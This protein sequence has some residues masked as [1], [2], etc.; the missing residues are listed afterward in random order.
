MATRRR[1]TSA[2]TKASS[3]TRRQSRQSHPQLFEGEMLV[4]EVE[5]HDRRYQREVAGHADQRAK[6]S[7]ATSIE[8]GEFRDLR[9][10][11]ARK[12]QCGETCVPAGGRETG[13]RAG[14]RH[15]RHDE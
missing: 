15:E 9:G 11:G 8:R 12:S 1:A 5:Q 6:Q 3:V 7:L 14:E 2:E 13:R 4:L 10:G